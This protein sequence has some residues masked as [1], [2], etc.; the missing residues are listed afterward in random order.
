MYGCIHF[1]SLLQLVLFCGL[2]M[3]YCFSNFLLWKWWVSSDAFSKY[4]FFVLSCSHLCHAYRCGVRNGFVQQAELSSFGKYMPM[5]PSYFPFLAYLYPHAFHIYMTKDE[6]PT[7]TI[8]DMNTPYL[9]QNI[10]YP[11]CIGMWI[12]NIS[13]LVYTWHIY[14]KLKIC[15]VSGLHVHTPIFMVPIS[16]CSCLHRSVSIDT[17]FSLNPLFLTL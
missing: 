17:L 6:H 14:E 12:S 4:I 5:S 3:A 11:Y 15:N 10:K 1:S 9:P 8:F 16:L 13:F 7:A 2:E